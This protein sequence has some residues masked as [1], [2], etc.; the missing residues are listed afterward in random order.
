MK[1]TDIHKNFI[2]TSSRSIVENFLPIKAVKPAEIP[3]FA[4][5]KWKNE[6]GLL[7]KKFI[8]EN[9]DDRNRFVNSILNYEMSSGHHANI[10]IEKNNVILRLITKDVDKV[11]ELDKEYS[12]Y[13]D[14]IRKDIAYNSRDE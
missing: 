14:T 13:A 12:S 2:K 9:L 7:T 11:T 6:N 5:E 8:F 10:T 4:I 1:L 3:V